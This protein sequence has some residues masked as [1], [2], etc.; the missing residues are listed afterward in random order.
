MVRPTRSGTRGEIVKISVF[1]SS[2]Q[3]A[4]HKRSGLECQDSSVRKKFSDGTVIMAVADGHGS[5]DCPYSKTGSTIAVRVFLDIMKQLHN[6]TD[7]LESLLTYLTR[8]GEMAVAKDIDAEWKRRIQKEHMNQ[9][10]EIGEN[11]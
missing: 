7:N 5:K 2:V 8:E 11:K 4:S 3:G 10:R 6:S 9:K 1:G